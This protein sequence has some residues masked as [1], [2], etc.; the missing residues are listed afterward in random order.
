M[1]INRNTKDIIT[2]IIVGFIANSFGI[3][4]W[5]ILFTKTEYD[6]LT[7][8]QVAYQERTFPAIIGMGALLNLL[9]FFGFLRMSFDYRAK[10]VLIA[11]F[12]SAFIILILK[13]I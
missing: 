13:F 1:K 3:L 12:I 11:T 6:F 10:G 7:T 9:A 2:G 4:F 5:W 8:I